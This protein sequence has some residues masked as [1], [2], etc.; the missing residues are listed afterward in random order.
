MQSREAGVDRAERHVR[1]LGDVGRRRADRAVPVSTQR[2]GERD[3]REGA[4]GALAQASPALA[5]HG[6]AVL[7]GAGDLSADEQDQPRDIAAEHQHGHDAEL[8][9]ERAELEDLADIERGQHLVAED[10]GARDQPADE[11]GGPA[12]ARVGQQAVQ[13]G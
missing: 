6:A 13:A 11:G 3:E 7:V 5:G 12:H 1:D 8:A 9:V 10:Q 4:A 2:L